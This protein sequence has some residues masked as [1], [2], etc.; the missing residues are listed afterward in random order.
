MFSTAQFIG[1]GVMVAVIIAI[2]VVLYRIEH[3]ISAQ[4][5][6]DAAEKARQAA[7]KR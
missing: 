3:S 4:S 7:Q 1:M 6:D 2:A 5:M